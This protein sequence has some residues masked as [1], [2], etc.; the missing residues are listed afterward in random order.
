MDRWG[1][2]NMQQKA[3]LL[4]IYVSKGYT[5]LASI[6]NHY[7][8]FQEGGSLGKVTPLG[9]WEYPHQVTTIPSNNITMKGVDY[10]VLGVSDTGDTKYMLPNMDYLFDGNYVTEYPLHK[11][12][13]G[14]KLTR[15]RRKDSPTQTYSESM[16]DR[17]ARHIQNFKADKINHSYDIPYIEEKEI[18][19]PGVGRVSANA[20]DSIAKYSYLA[21]IPLE[22]GLGLA[23]QESAFGA[24]PFLNYNK[25]PNSLPQEEKNRRA[26]A[27]RAL[28]NTSYFRNYG[29]IP[30]NYLVRDWHY[31]DL[32]DKQRET[33]PP[34]LDAFRYWKA[35]NYNRGDAN[36]TSD[37]KNKGRQV[38][39]TAPIQEW[40]STSPYVK[41]KTSKRKK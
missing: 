3:Q 14:G 10:P 12:Q 17:T 26:A 33:T 23:A 39:Q 1:N 15:V 19:V 20:L 5:N 30:A 8:T 4:G 27:N 38:I 16:E 35:G 11:F 32:T 34:L 21:G 9:Q 37:V 29:S 28:G 7:N 22:E 36:H 2:L 13:K 18:V 31:F 40:M 41:Q 6:I 24:I 25:I